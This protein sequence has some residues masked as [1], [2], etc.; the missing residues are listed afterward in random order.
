MEEIM[1]TLNTI[2]AAVVATLLLCVFMGIGILA[3]QVYIIKKIDELLKNQQ[4]QKL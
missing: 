4:K 3:N 2:G 1:A